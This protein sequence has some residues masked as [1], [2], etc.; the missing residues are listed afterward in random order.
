MIY[1]ENPANQ[2]YREGE[3]NMDM[4]KSLTIGYQFL[5]IDQQQKEGW[6]ESPSLAGGRGQHTV[7]DEEQHE[8]LYALLASVFGDKASCTQHPSEL[9]VSDGELNE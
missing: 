2:G 6:G 9:E 5:Q 8:V 1:K 4:S 7:R 3:K